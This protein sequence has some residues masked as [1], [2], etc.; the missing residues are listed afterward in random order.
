MAD[1][2]EREDRYLEEQYDRGEISSREFTRQ[3]N[4]LWRDYWDAARESAERA[5]E[6]EMNRW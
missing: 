4:E 6:E 1:E 3:V 2:W 5:C